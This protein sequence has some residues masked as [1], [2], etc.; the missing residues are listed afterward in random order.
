MLAATMTVAMVPATAFA[1]NSVRDAGGVISS[2]STPAAQDA[3]AVLEDEDAVKAALGDINTE[4][5]AADITAKLQA[6]FA[7]YKPEVVEGTLKKVSDVTA[8]YNKDD[9]KVEVKS[10]QVSFTLDLSDPT[11]GDLADSVDVVIEVPGLTKTDYLKVAEAYIE[12]AFA[13]DK[14]IADKGNDTNV[15]T[16]TQIAKKGIADSE[17]AQYSSKVKNYVKTEV[18]A[19]KPTIEKAN[20]DKG[21]SATTEVTV[22][23]TTKNE[24]NK[25]VKTT[26]KASYKKEFGP[27]SSSVDDTFKKIDADAAAKTL[28]DD[29]DTADKTEEAT[30]QD[31]PDSIKAFL[32]KKY[33]LSSNGITA[34]VLYTLNQKAKHDEDGKATLAV[35]LTKG[36]ETVQKNYDVVV[37]ESDKDITDEVT[38][39]ITD[40]VAKLAADTTE[41]QRLTAT[42]A[43]ETALKN[44]IVAKVEKALDVYPNDK[45]KVTYTSVHVDSVEIEKDGF[46]YTES[47]ATSKGQIKGTILAT[48]NIKDDYNEGVEIEVP[49]DF[50]L[51]E[52]KAV[53]AKEI[54]LSTDGVN[55]QKALH[56][57]VNNQNSKNDDIDKVIYAILT[58][59]TNK[60]GEVVTKNDVTFTSSDPSVVKVVADPDNKIKASLIPLKVGEAT[61]TASVVDE[62]GKTLTATMKVNVRKGFDDVTNPNSFYYD[63]VYRLAAKDVVNGTSATTFSPAAKVTRGQFVAFLYRLCREDMGGEM[64]YNTD[65]RA[66]YA[67][68]KVNATTSFTDVKADAYYA[69][70]VAWAASEGIVAGKSAT[71]F[72]PNAAVTRAEAVTFL[73]RAFGSNKGNNYTTIHNFTDVPSGKFYTAAVAWATTYPITA[74]KSATTFAP[75]DTC[76]RAEA[77]AFLDRV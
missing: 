73:Y 2:E 66:Q 65:G 7:N 29:P 33:D 35:Q 1:D 58:P 31:T 62:N 53:Y 19:A 15:S 17:L 70:A 12:K 46:T 71:K 52:F 23:L 50:T 32:D 10:A 59:D 40:E 21:G 39:N 37:K 54:K 6:V 8:S 56:L 41:L 72:D 4:S 14:T 48:L 45:N 25:D 16:V 3:K 38:K 68:K 24:D 26:D 44:Q 11:T 57:S 20:Y 34:N 63:A 27:T 55:E 69:E 75:Y 77:V 30:N 74:G 36:D 60:K 67:P 22:T 64:Y 42:S 47:T 9:K 76:T 28:F 49:F 18:S 5:S 51:A 13:E 61:I 43:N